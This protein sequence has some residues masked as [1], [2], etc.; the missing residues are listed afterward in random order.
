MRKHLQ[1][2]LFLGIIATFL[3]SCNA[4]DSASPYIPLDDAG[5]ALREQ[6]NKDIGWVRV[7]MLVAPT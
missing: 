1:R 4:E 3:N 7:V 2:F 5:K 6:F